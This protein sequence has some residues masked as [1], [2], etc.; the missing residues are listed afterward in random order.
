MTHL[1]AV[2]FM[3]SAAAGVVGA[4]QGL[5]F[6]LNKTEVYNDN[7]VLNFPF[8]SIHIVIYEAKVF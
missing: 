6:R 8:L 1:H 5:A 4:D 3:T 2:I 7:S